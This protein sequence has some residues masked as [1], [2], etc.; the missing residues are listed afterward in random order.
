MTITYTRDHDGVSELV[1]SLDLDDLKRIEMDDKDI[2]YFKEVGLDVFLVK[3]GIKEIGFFGI[4]GID[5]DNCQSP[6][7]VKKQFRSN[8]YGMKI[9]DL[10]EIEADKQN[11]SGVI[12]RIKKDNKTMMSLSKSCGYS[13]L[14]DDGDYSIMLKE[15]GL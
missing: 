2:N 10:A 14:V 13:Y 8:G 7:F 12:H 1:R 15:R 11:F 5:E 9:V 4:Y 6:L 3:D